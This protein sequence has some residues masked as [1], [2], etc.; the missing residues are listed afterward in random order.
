VFH[1]EREI[2]AL[3]DVIAA[4]PQ[5]LV[6][7][8]A[9]AALQR[10]ADDARTGLP[11]LEAEEGPLIDVGAG[12]GFPGIPLL[13]ARPG[14]RGVLLESRAR[15]CAH[16]VEAV[17]ACGLAERVEV[18]RDRAERYAAGGGREAAG[19]AVARALAPPPVAL[20]LCVPLVR[21]GG[22]VLLY[23]GAV[24]RP[25]LDEAAAMLGATVEQVQPVAGTERRTLV[26]VRRTAPLPPGLP[27]PV[28]RARRPRVRAA[29]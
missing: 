25:L 12:A 15:R 3:F 13:L 23:A 27:R 7:D 16:L 11:L 6:A 20:E 17:A 19:I 28:G 10:H 18:V 26:A 14:D 2:Q 24:E 21:P 9:T 4:S 5:R 8:S 29:G 22:L 1:V